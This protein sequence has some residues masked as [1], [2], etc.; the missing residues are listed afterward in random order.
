MI[1]DSQQ[2]NEMG[3][4]AIYRKNTIPTILHHSQKY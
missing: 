1:W 2:K 4:L 3:I